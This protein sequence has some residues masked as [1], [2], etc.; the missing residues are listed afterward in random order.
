MI[1]AGVD[2]GSL[3]AK[4]I[5]MKNGNILAQEIIRISPDLEESGREVFSMA[6]KSSS[7]EADDIEKI[8]STGY[9]RERVEFSDKRITEI[10][11][12]AE[13]ASWLIPSTRTVIDIGG[14]DSKIIFLESNG[15][16][17]DFTMN[18]KCAAGT[19]RF[20][21]VMSDALDMTLQE[22]GAFSTKNIDSVE[23]SSTCTVFAESEVIN[24]ISNGVPVKKIAAGI[25]E[26]I[27][28]RIASLA[29]R[30]PVKKDVVLTGGVAKNKGVKEALEK[31]LGF[32]I[33]IP[34]EPQ[35][36]GAVGAALFAKN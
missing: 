2:V 34:E 30:V 16:V 19:G 17:S 36:V 25:N 9:G 21:E 28:S 33:R 22:L 8:V 31:K 15:E 7:V 23:I 10:S 26:S 3:T 18:E 1:T 29:N 35:I 11:C 14:Q 4:S 13:G 12:H 6:L 24:H 27:A 20:L 5:I 32:E